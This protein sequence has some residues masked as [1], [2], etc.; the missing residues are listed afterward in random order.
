MLLLNCL[1]ELD[2]CARF[3]MEIT[4]NKWWEVISGLNEHFH[5]YMSH[6]VAVKDIKEKFLMENQ[7][8][9]NIKG[10]PTNDT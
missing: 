10:I 3:E 1:Q 8:P 5:S 7:V 6:D 2:N 4:S 9:E